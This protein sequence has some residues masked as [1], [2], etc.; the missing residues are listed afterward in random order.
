MVYQ[1]KSFIL[2][3][4]IR[5]N[6]LLCKTDFFSYYKKMLDKISIESRS[7]EILST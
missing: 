4:V 2:K 3:S 6:N 1:I 5:K 7:V